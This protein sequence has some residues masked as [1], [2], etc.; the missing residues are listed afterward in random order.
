MA[1]TCRICITSP[2]ICMVCS[3]TVFATGEL[4]ATRRS[5]VALVIFRKPPPPA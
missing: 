4:A 2:C 5:A 3:S 1:G